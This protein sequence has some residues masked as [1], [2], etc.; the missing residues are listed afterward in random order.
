MYKHGKF[1]LSV[2]NR[3]NLNANLKINF[4]QINFL[5]FQFDF[6]L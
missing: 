4:K 1:Y 5:Y 6:K 3:Y 2:L